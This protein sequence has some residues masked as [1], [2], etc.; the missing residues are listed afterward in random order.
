MR[1]LWLIPPITLA[2]LQLAT[3]K[4]VF[5]ALTSLSCAAVALIADAD[6]G[7]WLMAAGLAVSVAGDYLLAHQRGRPERFL[8]GVALFGAAHVIFMIYAARGYTFRPLALGF[9]ATLGLFY[10]M[11]LARS[12][13]PGQ[14]HA[15][16]IALS[17]YAAISLLGLFFALSMGG[18]AGPR[19]LYALA[20]AC[21]LF[22]DTMIAEAD[23]V[24]HRW[25]KGLILPTYYLCHILLAASRLAAP[26]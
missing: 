15:M 10:A 21:I 17:G 9:I 6:A 25:A 2:I 4:Y 1:F 13:L 19:W 3:R 22:S 12:V 24:H 16:R 7:G 14:T 23:F 20:I 18:P 5:S 8:Y 26:A 11:Y